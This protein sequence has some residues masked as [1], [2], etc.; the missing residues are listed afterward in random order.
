MTPSDDMIACPVC[1]VKSGAKAFRCREC[2]ELLP[3]GKIDHDK[4][5][6]RVWRD[7]PPPIEPEP[8]QS[9][10]FSLATLMLLITL[11]SICMA[12]S[13]EYRGLGIFVAVASVPPFLR[14]LLLARRR[15][16]FGL[17]MS[18][19]DKTVAFFASLSVVIASALGLAAVAGAAF[20]VTCIYS[21]GSGSSAPM[22]NL[23]IVAAV[24]AIPVIW[25]VCS[26]IHARW[27]DDL[28]S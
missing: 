5:R 19:G 20:F 2:G 12:L 15:K 4:V 3:A 27:H 7:P 25:L 21:L 11:A 28:Y 22:D 1:G 10:Q 9:A 8:S 13:R 6:R 17:P 14:T 24:L 26:K 18:P 23:P 16:Q